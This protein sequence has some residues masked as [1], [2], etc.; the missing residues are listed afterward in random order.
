MWKVFSQPW[1]AWPLSVEGLRTNLAAD[2]LDWLAV[3]EAEVD[4]FLRKA[5]VGTTERRVVEEG[6][7]ANRLDRVACWW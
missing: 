6:R 7:R 5:L 1:L 4:E 2:M 3:T